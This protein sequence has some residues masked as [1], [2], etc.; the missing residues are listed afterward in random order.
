M[1]T[2]YVPGLEL[3]DEDNNE[4]IVSSGQTLKLEH[5]LVSVSKWE[6]NWNKPFLSDDQKTTEESIDYIRCMTISQNIKPETYMNISNDVMVV[7]S[8]Y[9]EAS[10]TATTFLDRKRSM[11]KETITVEI[12]YYWMIT[13][14]IPKECEKWH[15]NRLLTLINVCNMK[16]KAPE[17][18]SKGELNRRNRDLNDARKK[19]LNSKG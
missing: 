9:I 15:L 6:S 7:I 10:M 3:F 19:A 17:K 12:I 16:S 1:L 8:Q 5:S 18:M 4:F 11:N 14:N 2:I 13:L